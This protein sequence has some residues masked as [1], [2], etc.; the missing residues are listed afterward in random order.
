M[1]TDGIAASINTLVGFCARRDVDRLTPDHLGGRADVAILFGGSILA[2]AAVFAEA[3][4]AGIAD[5]SLVV[6]GEGHSTDALRRQ[7]RRRT[8]WTDVDRLSEAALFD[9]YLRD[10]DG[11]V[12]DA[13]E[14]RSTNCGSNVTNALAL[15]DARGV[16]HDRI[17]L[18]QDATMQQRMDAGFR[19]HAPPATTLVNFASHRT[20]VR[21]VGDEVA[22][23][24]A[25]DGM[26]DLDR[27]VSLLMGEIPRLSD[28]VDGY[29]PRGRGYIA[30]VDVPAEVR[31]AFA[32]LRDTAGYA[33]RPADARWAGGPAERDDRTR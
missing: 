24:S 3:I 19:R 12:V 28:D 25:P 30:H 20:W 31:K 13:L 8:G 21:A 15:L 7:L 22:Y 4:R 18:V 11:L 6:G 17:V 14:E 10:H 2:G 9:R 26:W 23:E 1:R 5:F 27:Y 16:R 32:F 33:V 29:G